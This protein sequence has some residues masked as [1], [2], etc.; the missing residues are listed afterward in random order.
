MNSIILQTHHGPL[1]Q[2]KFIWLPISYIPWVKTESLY[3]RLRKTKIKFYLRLHSLFLCNFYS[4]SCVLTHTETLDFI[5]YIYIYIY[6]YIERERERERDFW[7]SSDD[8][9]LNIS[10]MSWNQ[11]EVISFSFRFYHTLL[12]NIRALSWF[13]KKDFKR[14]VCSLIKPPY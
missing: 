11:S 1:W 10:T 3:S 6:I 14:F 5:I 9:I 4:L 12:T 7:V 2:S 13:K 8:C